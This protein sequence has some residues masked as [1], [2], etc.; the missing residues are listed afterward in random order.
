MFTDSHRFSC[1]PERIQIVPSSESAINIFFVW[2]GGGGV[3][4]RT[5]E[6]D[7]WVQNPTR[8]PKNNVDSA[9]QQLIM[10]DAHCNVHNNGI[11]R[12]CPSSKQRN[13][14]PKH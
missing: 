9:L 11:P 4:V 2:G 13:E 7:S 14:I 3:S 12:L 8:N 1:K 6:K 5:E 10:A